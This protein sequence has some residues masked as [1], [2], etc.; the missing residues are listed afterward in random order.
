MAFAPGEASYT[1]LSHSLAHLY[2][3]AL[4]QRGTAKP[5]FPCDPGSH[6]PHGLR[7]LPAGKSFQRVAG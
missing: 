6:C 4:K 2:T 7:K 3:V 5:L 1:R